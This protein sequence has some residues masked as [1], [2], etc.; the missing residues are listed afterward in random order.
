VLVEEG[1]ALYAHETSGPFEQSAAQTDAGGA[2]REEGVDERGVHLVGIVGKHVVVH[3][4]HMESCVGGVG[5]DAPGQLG[6]R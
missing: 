6:S 3:P 4:S 1:G 2:E 5:R